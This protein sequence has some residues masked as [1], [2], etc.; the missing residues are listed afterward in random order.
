MWILPA[1]ALSSSEVHTKRGTASLRKSHNYTYGRHQMAQTGQFKA[2]VWWWIRCYQAL[3]CHASFVRFS[4]ENGPFRP[5]LPS[6]TA[7]QNPKF[8]QRLVGLRPADRFNDFE[9]IATVKRSDLLAIPVSDDDAS[10]AELPENVPQLFMFGLRKRMQVTVT[11]TKPWWVDVQ[12]T[13]RSVSNLTQTH[14]PIFRCPLASSELFRPA[15]QVRS[16]RR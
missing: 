1:S 7:V 16:S 4:R 9:S 10:R 12:A 5:V 2:M 14:G 6:V 11:G 15:F 13:I 8:T 3:H